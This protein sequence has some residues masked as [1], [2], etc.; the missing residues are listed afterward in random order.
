[1]AMSLDIDVQ[2]VVARSFRGNGTNARDP[3][4]LRPWQT[5]REKILHRR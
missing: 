5:Q 3:H 1:M 2:I 4:S